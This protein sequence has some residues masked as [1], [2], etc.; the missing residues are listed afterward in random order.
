MHGDGSLSN[1][2]LSSHG[3]VRPIPTESASTTP[4]S[5]ASD[6]AMETDDISTQ[7][8][9]VSHALKKNFDRNFVKSESNKTITAVQEIQQPQFGHSNGQ[10]NSSSIVGVNIFTVF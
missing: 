8:Q 2:P 9:K 6:A 5:A 7:D 3:G 1:T 4:L 10:C